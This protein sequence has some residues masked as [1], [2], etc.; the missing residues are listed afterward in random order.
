MQMETKMI[1]MK[2]YT[3]EDRLQ[4]QESN[5]KQV[6]VV[7]SMEQNVFAPPLTNGTLYKASFG[8]EVS[9]EFDA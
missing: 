1:M 5:W 2:L 8:G 9:N 6:E 3:V 7:A 4:E